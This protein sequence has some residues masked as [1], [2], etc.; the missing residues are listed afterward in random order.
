MEL[1]ELLTDRLRRPTV[2]LTGTPFRV[3]ATYTRDEI[4]AGLMELRKG[5]LMRTQ[6]GVFESKPARAGVL[7][8]TL[9]KDP[10]HFTPTTL[11]RDY[12]I[13]PKRFHWESQGVTRAETATGRRY[14]LTCRRR[15]DFEVHRSLRIG[16]RPRIVAAASQGQLA[17]AE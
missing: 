2:A 1:F 12:P 5:K 14:Q 3:H 6:G 13:S 10:R 16:Y 15:G 11:Y 8:V 9:D 17:N 7:Y 4:S